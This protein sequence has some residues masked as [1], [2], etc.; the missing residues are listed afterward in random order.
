VAKDIS[1]EI[2]EREIEKIRK[3]AEVDESYAVGLL[4]SSPF[5]GY[6]EYADKLVYE[7]FIHDI[8]GFLYELGRRLYKSG[9]KTFDDISV[10]KMVKELNVQEQ[11]EK[12][13]GFETIED[14]INIVGDSRDN[15][16]HYYESIKKAKTIKDLHALFGDKVLVE[17]KKYKPLVMDKDVLYAYWHDKVNNVGLSNSSV[18][19]EAESLYIDADDFINQLNQ[20]AEDMLPWH[21]SPLMNKLSQ[22]VAKGTTNFLCGYGGSGK[23]SVGVAKFIMSY[24]KNAENERMLA[25]LNEETANSF[26]QKVVLSILFYEF[27][28][29]IDRTRMVNGKLQDEDKDKIRKAFAKMKE[30]MDGD[31][32]LITV[33]YLERYTIE[34]LEK[35]INYYKNRGISGIFLDT[36][37]ALDDDNSSESWKSFVE[38]SKLIYKLSRKTS[39]HDGLRTLCTLQLADS[40]IKNRYLTFDSIGVA[41]ASKNETSQVWLF[42]PIFDDEYP[43]QKK[44]LFTYTMQKNAKTGK[45][46]KIPHKLDKDKTYYLFFLAKC[47]TG[48]NNSNGAPVVVVE[49]LFNFNAFL[50]VCYAFVPRDF[51]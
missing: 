5:D 24:L 51:I 34:N 6:S 20:E 22:G 49:P 31:D 38:A 45:Y 10:Q 2:A 3:N 14:V 39:T 40:G 9:L 26:R 18:K 32:A 25:I 42:R 37:K 11:W 43:N 19:F 44:E 1:R 15:I 29:G 17:T 35:I 4:W 50:D 33:I 7:D 16:E 36:H 27:G 13:N 23:S 12:Y 48:A 21:D 47:R 46:E 8:W 28:T 41:K 30:L